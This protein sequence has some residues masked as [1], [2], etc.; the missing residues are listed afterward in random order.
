VPPLLPINIP[1]SS[2]RHCWIVV[3]VEV[4]LAAS[5]FSVLVGIILLSLLFVNII[6][7]G[8]IGLGNDC[9]LRIRGGLVCNTIA[10]A[11]PLRRT[12]G[13]SSLLLQHSP[14]AADAAAE[15]GIDDES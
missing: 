15:A 3:V 14:P 2:D 1:P 12:C 13:S 9:V 11:I 6:G 8:G 5:S 10:E 7:G 4:L